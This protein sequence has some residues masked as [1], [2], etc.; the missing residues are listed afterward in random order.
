MSSK[1]APRYLL[2]HRRRME[3]MGV[4]ADTLDALGPD[5]L[6]ETALIAVARR[7]AEADREHARFLLLSGPR[8]TGK[9][10]AAAWALREFLVQR[11]DWSQPSGGHAPEDGG[12]TLMATFA[13]ISGY[14]AEDKAWFESLCTTRALVLDDFGAEFAGP[15]GKAMLEELVMRR[16]AKRLRTV[17]TSNLDLAALKARLDE[18]LYD[19]IR[20]TCIVGIETGESMRVRHRAH[21]TERKHTSQTLTGDA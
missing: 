14:A 12:W 20:T 3:R 11:P 13:R 15:F 21:W 18:R 2:E 6:R 4:D 1:A 9:S 8:G 7:F 17:L 5:R 10:V 19:R 16:H